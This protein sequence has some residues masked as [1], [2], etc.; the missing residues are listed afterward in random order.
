M[1]DSDQA[2]LEAYAERLRDELTSPGM[3]VREIVHL[4]VLQARRKHGDLGIPYVDFEAS[5]R[6]GE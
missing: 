4:F 5:S 2:W 1:Y 3:M 6:S